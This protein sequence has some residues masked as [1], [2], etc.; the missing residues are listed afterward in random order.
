MTICAA[1]L[2][3]LFIFGLA[4]FLCKKNLNTKFTPNRDNELVSTCLLLSAFLFVPLETLPPMVDI[5]FG[6]LI[7]LALLFFANCWQSTKQKKYL[8]VIFLTIIFALFSLL[9]YFCGIPGHLFCIESYSSPLIWQVLSLPAK[10]IYILLGTLF[11][12]LLFRQFRSQKIKEREASPLSILKNLL[13]IAIFSA[14]FLPRVS[15]STTPFSFTSNL[16]IFWL[17]WAKILTIYGVIHC[18][19]LLRTKNS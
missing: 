11:V 7:L 16:V 8:F 17:G 6:S 4:I 2:Y 10:G 13:H 5:E 12:A 9:V 3:L 15:F 14:I 18:F 1:L 19:H